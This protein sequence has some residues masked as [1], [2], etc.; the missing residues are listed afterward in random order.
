MTGIT[1]VNSGD[2]TKTVSPRYGKFIN[3]PT[4]FRYGKFINEPTEFCIL[5]ISRNAYTIEGRP[6]IV[7]KSD[8]AMLLNEDHKCHF[9]TRRRISH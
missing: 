7:S 4:E 9:M 3:E 5:I 6:T 1:T 8:F 2:T